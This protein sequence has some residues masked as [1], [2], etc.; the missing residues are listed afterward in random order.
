MP[1]FLAPTPSRGRPPTHPKISGPKSLG[2][3]SLF[4]PDLWSK[5]CSL[6]VLWATFGVM[7]GRDCLRAISGKQFIPPPLNCKSLCLLSR[8]ILWIFFFVFAWEF[9]IEKW[10]GFLVNFFWSPSPTKRSTKSPWKIRGKIRAEN[11]K[12]SGNFVLQLLWPNKMGKK[13][14]FVN[15]PKWV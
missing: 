15:M 9:C 10:R 11:S 7:L 8:R 2:L 6:P 13:W 4:S 14:V 3:G 5:V 12:N 1:N